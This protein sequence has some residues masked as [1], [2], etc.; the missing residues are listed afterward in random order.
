MLPGPFV[1]PELPNIPGNIPPVLI[2][3]L[4]VLAAVL[5]AVTFFRFI[6][7]EPGERS[8]NFFAFFF[9]VLLVLALYLALINADKIETFLENLA[10]PLIL[11][12][13]R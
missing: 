3:A 4:M 2:W 8:T 12:F 11:R 7:A 10:R 6:F 1:M 9:A 13:R 5:L